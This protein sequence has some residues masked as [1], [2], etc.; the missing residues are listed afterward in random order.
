MNLIDLEIRPYCLACHG[1]GLFWNG[2]CDNM[3]ICI[4]CKGRARITWD[5]VELLEVE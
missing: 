3:Q 1:K 2:G 4:A 5:Q